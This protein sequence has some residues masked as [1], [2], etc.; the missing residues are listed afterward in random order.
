MDEVA[1]VRLVGEEARKVVAARQSS[2]F[3]GRYLTGANILDVGFRGYRDDVVPIV[4]GAVGVELDFPGYDGVTLPFADATQDAVFSSHCLEHITDYANAIRDWFRVLKIGG[5]LVIMVPHQFLYE[6]R[7]AMPSVYNED[8][9]RFYTPAS[10]MAEIETSLAP[11]SYR[12]RHLVDNDLGFDYSLPPERHSGGSYEIEIVI[13]KIAPPFWDL[14]GPPL[15][16]TEMHRRGRVVV[17]EAATRVELD[18]SPLVSHPVRRLEFGRT[19]PKNPRILVMKLDHLG[20]FIIGLPSL[21]RLREAFPTAFIRLVVG[22]WNR[23]T[24]EATGLVDEVRTYDYFPQNSAGWD[25]KPVE[26]REK[27]QAA[28]ADR[29]DL[30][31][32]LRVDDD[33]RMLLAGVDAGLRAGIGSPARFPF[34]DIA[35]PPE[36]EERNRERSRE[37]GQGS[38][39]A[40]RLIALD[41]FDSNMPTQHLFYHETD[42]RAP[43]V[44]MI[45]GPHI[46]LPLGR[47]TVSF[48]L[49]FTGWLGFAKSAVT[50]DVARNGEIVAFKRLEARELKALPADGVEIEFANEDPVARW[51]FRVFVEGKSRQA[52]IRFAGVRLRHAEA[53]S[54]ARLKKATLHIGEQLSLLVQL[55][56]DRLQALYHSGPGVVT[57][58]S[59]ERHVVVAPISNSKLRDWP[60]RHYGTLVRRLVDELGCRVS[61]VGAPSQKEQLDEIMGLSGNGGVTNLAGMTAWS[62]MP[63]LLHGAALVVCNNSGTAHAAAAGGARTLAIYS[64]SHQPEEW[65]PRGPHSRA[66]TAIVPC[67]PC[68]W[69]KLS[70]CPHDHA[71]MVGLSPDK[72]F[73]E[74]KKLLAD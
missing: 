16:Q 50:L 60:A 66:L 14:A 6:K 28:T 34:L 27:L 22:S 40:R 72:V 35:L 36:H 49:Q 2:G 30:A 61:L 70:D 19:V 29:F 44:H 33:T 3:T 24:A 46:T 68:G 32:D 52:A 11:N 10:L 7:L 71:C 4:E 1:A 48:A 9:K 67:S 42:F 12:L 43:P 74:A 54:G 65:G 51:E 45:Y 63:A 47:F 41:Q 20:D 26:P 59:G 25:G 69:D 17:E 56:H 39:K 18:V 73:D 8:H 5:F 57:G 21:G 37:R 62:D 23:V 38:D 58:E 15:W 31:I 13:E 55:T 53:P 64:A